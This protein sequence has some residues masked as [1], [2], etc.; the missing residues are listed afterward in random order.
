MQV[1]CC[2]DLWLHCNKKWEVQRKK[3]CA[4]KFEG[5]QSPLISLTVR[6]GSTCQKVTRH[7]WKVDC[8]VVGLWLGLVLA[9][10]LMVMNLHVQ[11]QLLPLFQDLLVTS[12][13]CDVLTVFLRHWQ[14]WM[15]VIKCVISFSDVNTKMHNQ[16]HFM[17]HSVIIIYLFCNKIVSTF[18]SDNKQF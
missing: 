7:M 8:L 11:C 13:P 1:M 4:W 14:H 3:Q 16:C 2:P 5:Q 12:W 15:C 18:T 9:L 17:S 6:Y 10:V